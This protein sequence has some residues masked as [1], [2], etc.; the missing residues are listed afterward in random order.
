MICAQAV[1]EGLTLLHGVGHNTAA[2]NALSPTCQEA[3]FAT[4]TRG[5]TVA[6]THMQTVKSTPTF[7]E[8][9]LS[10]DISGRVASQLA[11]IKV[12]PYASFES[13]QLRALHAVLSM[14]T[15][16]LQILHAFRWDEYFPGSLLI[17]NAPVDADLPPTPQDE[18]PSRAK[19][20]YISEGFLIG[21]SQFLGET[22]GFDREKNG[23]LIHDIRPLLSQ[24]K[25]MS[26]GGADVDFDFHTEVAFHPHR[27]AF[28]IL[29]CLREDHEGDAWTYVA[30]IKDVW[31]ELTA[32]D[33]NELTT[34]KFLFRPPTTFAAEGSEP[35][36][37]SLYGRPIIYGL[38]SRPRLC[39]N[40]NAGFLESDA[41]GI[42]AMH[43]LAQ[44][45]HT[46]SD[47]IRL[48][49]GDMLLLDNRKVVHGRTAFAAKFDGTDRWL[50]RAYVSSGLWESEA[51][52]KYPNRVI[53]SQ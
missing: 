34:P 8:I 25:S 21:C 22:Y 49:P 31:R 14:P 50:Q 23:R 53:T 12:S 51:G 37:A 11:D 26:S 38:P 28:L 52:P 29:F 44:V 42:E 46:H 20:T 27:P 16:V 47:S 4:R 2:F 9:T 19:H 45:L 41:A 5:E 7:R 36:P 35:R 24:A 43:R 40:C 6:L 10:P 32:S 1:A 39:L 33:I 15:S 13:F 30:D 3:P 48:L 18:A 17:R